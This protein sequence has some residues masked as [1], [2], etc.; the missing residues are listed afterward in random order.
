MCGRIDSMYYFT[1]N[2]PAGQSMNVMNS[3]FI[4]ILLIYL[5]FIIFAVWN[6]QKQKKG[7]NDL[8]NTQL[9]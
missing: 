7:I 6:C 8:S 9:R 2:F 1:D 3:F 5:F 4:L